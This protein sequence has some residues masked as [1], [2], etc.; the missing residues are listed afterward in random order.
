MSDDLIELYPERDPKDETKRLITGS[1]SHPLEIDHFLYA[2]RRNWARPF[3]ALVAGGGTGDALVQMAQVLQSA[4]KSHEI[5]YLDPSPKA[6]A[7]AEARSAARGLTHIRFDTGALTDADALRALGLFDYIDC[8][9][10]LHHLD[11]PAA[12]LSDLAGLLTE[13][14][15]MGLMV[16]APYGR[17]GVAPVRDGLQKVLSTGSPRERL[18]RARAIVARLPAGHPIRQN[19]QLA[20]QLGS[21]AGFYDLLLRPNG[22]SYGIRAFSDLITAAGLVMVGQPQAHLYNPSGLV[23]DAKLLRDMDALTRMELAEQLNGTIRSHV[24]YV[25]RG[26][27][28]RLARNERDAVPHLKGVSGEK[29]AQAAAKTGVI[30]VSFAGTVAEIPVTGMALKALT[31]VN[32]RAS[33][34]EIAVETGLDAVSFSSIW[35]PLSEALTAYGLMLYSRLLRPE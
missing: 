9:G 10:V 4:G 23:G 8:S 27:E 5:V 14:G 21:D 3:R 7:V 2:G 16:H 31:H 28:R 20:D 18:R 32:G 11:D 17:S 26:A 35:R 1:P 15:G 12:V 30:P 34:E 25:A 19:P 33:L 22:R 29:L 13:D 6:R 24:A